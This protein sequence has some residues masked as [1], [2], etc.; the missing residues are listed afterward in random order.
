MLKIA[1]SPKYAH[2]LPAGH[3]FPMEKYELLPE[4]LLYE[5]TIAAHNLFEPNALSEEWIVGPHKAGYLQKLTELSLTKS[6][7]RKTG[8]PLSAA[9]VERE[10]HIMDGS[11]Q[12]CLFA[13]KHGIAMNIAGGT[14][15]AFSDRGEGFCLLNDIAISANYLVQKK[16]AKQVLVVDLDVHQ[17]NGTAEIFKDNPAVFT[18]SMHGAANYP[19][20]KE[21]SDLD[22]PLPDKVGDEFY[23]RKLKEHLPPLLDQVEPDFIIYQCGVDVLSTDKLGRLGVSI[24]GCKERDRLVLELAHQH[25]LPIMCCMGGGYSE[26]ISHIIEAHAN[27]YRLAQELFF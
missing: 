24:E 27:T 25:E 14:H 5:G 18:F 26:K 16:L 13:L 17:G 1:W 10:I 6:E 21:T 7:I 20:H 8:F 2:P 12:G 19:L 22:V 4:Q 3:R 15:H 11:V 9:L 23:I